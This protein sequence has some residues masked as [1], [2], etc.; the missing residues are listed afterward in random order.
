MS[1][2]R[3]GSQELVCRWCMQFRVASIMHPSPCPWCRVL[4]VH[5]GPPEVQS[6]PTPRGAGGAEGAH[7][8]LVPTEGSTA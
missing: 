3:E 2:V 8:H 1:V 5:G 4:S 7:P 6:S